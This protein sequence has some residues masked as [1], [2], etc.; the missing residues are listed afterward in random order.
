MNDPSLSRPRHAALQALLL[1]AIATG[2]VAAA[3]ATSRSGTPGGPTYQI[4]RSH[5]GAGGGRSQSDGPGAYQ[6]VGTIA[7]PAP[8]FASGSHQLDA[9]FWHADRPE[10]LEGVRRA[11]AGSHIL[12]DATPAAPGERTPQWN[13]DTPENLLR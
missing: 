12:T 11:G 9:G 10:L 4:V 13:P 7:Q 1:L 6:V 8:G 3:A 2:L 5:V